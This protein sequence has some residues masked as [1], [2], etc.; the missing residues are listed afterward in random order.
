MAAL[1]TSSSSSLRPSS[2][3]GVRIADCGLAEDSAF[4]NP[5]SAIGRAASS[6]VT[7]SPRWATSWRSAARASTTSARSTFSDFIARSGLQGDQP[8]LL[9]RPLLALGL[10]VLKSLGQVLARVGRLDDVIHQPAAG[11]D[12]G[13]GEGGAVLLD[14]LGA[15][16]C[17]V[18]G[19]LHLLA[20]DDLHRP[21]GPHD[22]DL[23]GGPG[24]DA[25]GAQVAGA[26]RQVSAAVGLA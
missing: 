24:E 20:E 1:M 6:A 22:G 17:L 18:L 10:Q 3:C 19:L 15:A 26:H 14:Q 9:R 11:G 7:R 12:I 16:G 23:G 8:V 25:V 13:G 2:D 21:L 4:R 5:R